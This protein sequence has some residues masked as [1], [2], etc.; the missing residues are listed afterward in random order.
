MACAAPF[1]TLMLV[2]I[3]NQL[4]APA[5]RVIDNGRFLADAL[6][7]AALNEHLQKAG[8]EVNGNSMLNAS[9]NQHLQKLIESEKSHSL[10]DATVNEGLQERGEGESGLLPRELLQAV[11]AV[12]WLWAGS[13][14]LLAVRNI[15]TAMHVY[16]EKKTIEKEMAQAFTRSR[17]IAFEEAHKHQL[18]SEAM[19]D[20]FSTDSLSALQTFVDTSARIAEH[21]GANETES[22]NILKQ[23]ADD[24]QKVYDLL[25]G[26]VCR[27]L[28][29]ELEDYT[30]SANALAQQYWKRVPDP[31]AYGFQKTLYYTI[32]SKHNKVYVEDPFDEFDTGKPQTD[33]EIDLRDFERY[34]QPRDLEQC[35]AVPEQLD[36]S[37]F[38]DRARQGLHAAPPLPDGIAQEFEQI[39]NKV[40]LLLRGLQDEACPSYTF[41]ECTRRVM[42]CTYGTRTMFQTLEAAW[43]AMHQASV[44][45][46]VST[47]AS[48][49]RGSWFVRALEKFTES[50]I[51]KVGLVAWADLVGEIA[52]FLHRFRTRIR[53]LLTDSGMVPLTIQM[54]YELF[55]V[56]DAMN[57]GS[58]VQSF[59]DEV[60]EEL[61]GVLFSN[62]KD[63]SMPIIAEW[64]QGFSWLAVEHAH[65][66]DVS[67]V[68]DKAARLLQSGDH[69]NMTEA[70]VNATEN[71]HELD[72]SRI[73]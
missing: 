45:G 62:L 41:N 11:R 55:F 14:S 37:S 52:M 49:R 59:F 73:E 69:V 5:R 4:I 64:L 53:K 8:K 56:K 63:W 65:A 9:L 6:G 46:D 42:L 1:R 40:K 24:A 3:G 32:A 38:T 17:I 30:E 70:H 23:H 57:V 71:L 67:D 66:V 72:Q 13:A 10:L 25:H 36:G 39:T 29:Q 44:A 19:V 28:A 68:C 58:S 15:Y 22:G 16:K 2:A 18:D 48:K 34:C 51:V 21:C 20:I 33:D 31:E 27:G 60:N 26:E 7:K 43:E 12:R 54:V 50:G 47:S 61:S 35:S